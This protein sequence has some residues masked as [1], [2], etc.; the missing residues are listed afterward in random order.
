MGPNA[1]LPWRS[2]AQKR[3]IAAGLERVEA[4]LSDVVEAYPGA[5][6][7]ASASTLEAGG[8]RLRP[9]LVLL[10]ARRTGSFDE[11][12]LRAAAAVE[13]L[14]MATLVHDDVLDQA[15]LRRGRPTVAYQF[16]TATAVS[17][18][19]FLLARAFAQIAMTRDARAVDALSGVA[20]GISEGELLQMEQAFRV[21]LSHADYE[22]RCELKTAG[23][24]AV[25]CRLGALLSG[26]SESDA[27]ALAEYGR[28]LGLAFQIF[29][30]ILDLTGDEAKTGKRVGTDLRDGTVTLPMVLALQA[31]PDLGPRLQRCA[32]DEACL[33]D[34]VSEVG[35]SGALERAREIALSYSAQAQRVLAACAADAEKD[36][37]RELADSVVDRYS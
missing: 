2:A 24:F 36:L 8:K 23:L 1:I 20:L 25:S 32:D 22:R 19:N 27:A 17:V 7:D 35:A 14:H 37:L 18:G 21:G 34:V 30:D 11:P 15:D 9:V 3:R 4:I 12:V 6:G 13:L 26:L 29:D 16:G 10:S 31:R 28:L 5:L 33:A